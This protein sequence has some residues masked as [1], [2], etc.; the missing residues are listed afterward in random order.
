M[1][2]HISPEQLAL[3]EA[4]RRYCAGALDGGLRREVF[5]RGD[6]FDAGFWA[7]LMALG[8]G[9]LCIDEAHGGLG[10][11]FVDL[12]LVAEVLGECAAPGPFLGHVLAASAIQRAGTPAQQA[13]W[14]PKLASGECIATIA[15]A[16]AGERWAPS[17]WTLALEGDRLTGSKTAVIGAAQAHLVVVG[18]RG[19]GL[20]LVE[21]QA[22]TTNVRVLDAVDRT[23]DLG[24]LHFE[25]A[26]AERLD[27]ASSAAEDFF[28][29]LGILLA[30]DAFGGAQHCLR[31]TVDY[32]K[33]RVQFGVPIGS[34]QGMKH[35]LANLA[36]ALEPARGLW[37]YAALAQDLRQDDRARLAA[38]AKAHLSDLFNQTAR[39][40]VELHGGIGFTWEHDLQM[41]VKRA[42]FDFAFA[43][44]PARHRRWAYAEEA[45]EAPGPASSPG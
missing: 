31:A 36:C 24:T 8:A 28:A 45:G 10:L 18:L 6:G 19:G 40:A 3:Q 23:R 25:G 16:E 12:A 4:V 41:W 42:M 17:E 29:Q 34:F 43:G 5:E 11:G 35:R 37:W 9:G 2:F 7:G 38:L 39:A 33:S 27:A 1:N 14:L 32:A 21:A 20:A 22:T 26:R 13:R 44:T 30:A 15:L